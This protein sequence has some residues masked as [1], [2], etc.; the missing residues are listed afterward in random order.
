[1]QLLRVAIITVSATG[2]LF[3]NC[4]TLFSWFNFV[5]ASARIFRKPL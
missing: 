2:Y 3:N 1:M 5:K 4:T